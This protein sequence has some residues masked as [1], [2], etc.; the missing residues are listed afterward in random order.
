[1]KTTNIWEKLDYALFRIKDIP[2]GIKGLWRTY[3]SKKHWQ[4]T[5]KLPRTSW[6]DS[7]RR[8]LY[9][10]MQVLDEYYRDEISLDIVDWVND[11]HQKEVKAKMDEIKAWWDNYPNR[12]KAIDNKLDAWYNCRCETRKDLNIEPDDILG[13]V[14]KEQTDEEKQ[15]FDE[16]SQM[17]IKLIEEEQ[18]MLHK[19]VDIRREMWT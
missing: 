4:I 1:M 9:G 8:I 13:W 3:V 7:D 15:L 6:I 5:T 11:P 14:N 17:E 10:M 18:E 19:L 16:L 2:Y 12:V